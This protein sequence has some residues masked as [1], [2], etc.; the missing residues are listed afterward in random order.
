[1]TKALESPVMQIATTS[2]ITVTIPDPV[3]VEFPGPAVYYEGSET[4]VANTPVNVIDETSASNQRL[5]RVE[6]VAAT[7]GTFE[8]LIDS[9]V[10]KTGKTN[11]ALPIVSLPFEPWVSVNSGQNIKLVFTQSDGP[12]VAVTGKIYYTNN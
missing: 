3:N 2:P 1:M 12:A 7:Y 6:F 11:P 9:V 10:I 4:S 8:V 5:R